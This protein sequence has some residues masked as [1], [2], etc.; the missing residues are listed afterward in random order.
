VSTFEQPRASTDSAASQA[1][2]RPRVDAPPAGGSR[3]ELDEALEEACRRIPPLWTLRSFVAVN[4]YLGFT[5]QP[6]HEAVD[7]LDR[8]FHARTFMP[9][10]FYRGRYQR[11]VVRD[12][13]VA[14]ACHEAAVRLGR[15]ELAS[16]EPPREL[17]QL[18]DGEAEGARERVLTFSEAMDRATGSAWAPMVLDE[19]SKWCAAR[20]DAGQAGWPMPWAELPL[21]A[22]WR[23]AALVDRS[24]EVRGLTGFR[25]SVRALPE[26]PRDAIGAV[27]DQLEVPRD[28]TARFLARA[29]ASVAGWAGHV[30]LRVRKAAMEGS[31]DDS[32][33]QLLA[34]RLA[35]EAG[36]HRAVGGRAPALAGGAPPARPGDA[37]SAGS[38]GAL[39]AAEA[40]LVWQLALEAAYRRELLGRIASGPPARAGAG[41]RPA[42]QAVFCIDVRSEVLRRH[43]EA[44]S[45]RVRTLGFAGF[46]GFP[47]ETLL[48]GDVRGAVR[49]PVLIAPSHVVPEA[50]PGRPAI[51]E[52]YLRQQERHKTFKA[53]RLSTVSAF[54][55]VETLGPLFG[56]RLVGDTLTVSRP[57]TDGRLMRSGAETELEPD[58]VPRHR[59]GRPTGIDLDDRVA[60]AESALRGMGLLHGFAETVLL[61]G[62]GS[63]TTNNPYG[64][65][66]D[67][68]ACGGHAGDINARVA[69]AVLE[70]PDVRKALAERGIRIPEDTRFV[71]GLHETTS[72]TVHLLDRDRLAPGR[73]QRIEAWLDEAG[74]RAGEERERRLRRR[75]E[76]TPW[77][78]GRRR[79]RD[80]S[81]VRPEWGL[82]RNAAIVAAP[83]ERTEDVDLDG[84]VFLHDYH[85]DRDPE[86]HVLEVVMTAPLVVASWINLQYYAS[87]V[88]N[89]VFGS[90]DKVLHNVV[91]RHGVMLGN[92]SDLRPGLPWQSVHDGTDFVHEPLRLLAVFEAP[93]ERIARILGS[94]PEVEEL[95]SNGW[96]HLVARE[97]DGHDFHRWV[98]GGFER[99]EEGPG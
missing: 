63:D 65:G 26:K 31:Q 90:G 61:C 66:L 13:D 22:A 14:T 77:R 5:G 35:Y 20:F 38:A 45:P 56:L 68:G 24:P 92:R 89:D 1:P 95:V 64:S 87:T 37:Q 54:P 2:D 55:F 23:E 21:F 71:A 33:V 58:L 88:D 83:R 46:F 85:A 30:Q 48:P 80:W 99:L 49:C 4:P 72:D 84:R 18:D 17:W 12:E 53:L 44:A 82:A 97:P 41:E 40:Q 3:P 60:L 39:T 98:D 94:H 6:F 74:R 8:V 96:I 27:L 10:A 28:A 78:A 43:L 50:A 36:V 79:A 7:E 70:D 75:P 67:C 73:R 57:H 93:L 81:E 62:H 19:M 15:P 91:G 29:L 32:L 9:L 25:R 42:L 86:G 16:G 34:I 76:R 47:I 51:E 59:D 52:R 11:G 69:A